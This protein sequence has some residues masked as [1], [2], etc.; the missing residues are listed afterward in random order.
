MLHLTH[1][2]QRKL[3]ALATQNGQ[4]IEIL[5][6]NLLRLAVESV[7]QS[8]IKETAVGLREVCPRSYHHRDP[9]R[10]LSEIPGWTSYGSRA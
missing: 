5:A 6:N 8:G 1:D 7:E 3:E 2:V 10:A 9:L 4:N